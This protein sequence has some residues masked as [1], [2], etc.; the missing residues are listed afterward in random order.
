VAFGFIAF[1]LFL[2][3]GLNLAKETGRH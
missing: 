3:A 2:L 1:S